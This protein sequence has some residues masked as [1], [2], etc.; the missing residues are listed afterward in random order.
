MSYPNFA[1]GSK[2]HLV[3]DN[4]IQAVYTSR[5]PDAY[6]PIPP[7][8]LSFSLAYRYLR[9]AANNQNAR[10]SWKWGGNA[11]LLVDDVSQVEVI[12]R[13]LRCNQAIIIPVPDY[14]ERYRIKV[15]VPYWFD[16]VSLQ[17]DGY[18]DT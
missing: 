12:R 1:D 11:D 8:S 10:A 4:L 9:I 6:I 2:W 13:S 18:I 15:S 5:N 16:E 14:L 7:I 17:I 3:F